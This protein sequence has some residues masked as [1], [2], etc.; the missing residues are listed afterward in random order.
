MENP[1]QTVTATAVL[2][3]RGKKNRRHLAAEKLGKIDNTVDVP[4]ECDDKQYLGVSVTKNA[5]GDYSKDLSDRRGS[6][7]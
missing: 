7:Q 6:R 5:N 4:N 3:G 1:L 2:K